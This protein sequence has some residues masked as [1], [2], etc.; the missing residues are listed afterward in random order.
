MKPIPTIAVSLLLGLVAACTAGANPDRKH[1]EP[2]ELAR[3][4]ART[5]PAAPAKPKAAEG[6]EAPPRDAETAAPAARPEAPPPDD[7]PAAAT[8]EP[9]REAPTGGRVTLPV[10]RVAD[11]DVD[12]REL[13][14]RWVVR[15]PG[16]AR[17][18]LQQLVVARLALVE[19]ARLGI[20]L[21]PERVDAEMEEAREGMAREIRESGSARTLEQHVEEVLGLDPDF[22]LRQLRRETITHLLAERAVRTW[23]LESPRRLLEV[24]VLDGTVPVE[25]LQPVL[26]G[27]EDLDVLAQ[28][29]EAAGRAQRTRVEVVE[30]AHSAL[31]R[32]AFATPVGGLVG[33]IDENGQRLL[34]R[35]EAVPDVR[36]GPWSE[37]GP[38]VEASLAERPIDDREYV[39]WKDAM[40]RRYVVDVDPFLDLVDQ[41]P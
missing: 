12:V 26:G 38:E 10:A 41:R 18:E 1:L 7:P 15:S 8:Q 6:S 20:S 11:T 27:T 33:P 31:A 14:A 40:Q 22:Y 17:Q 25:D 36:V 3:A 23:I 39:Q 16:A 13:L 4:P 21:S 28:R 9:A 37:V 29:L 32:A 24:L 19:A 35:V 5:E 30:S 34:V 2:V